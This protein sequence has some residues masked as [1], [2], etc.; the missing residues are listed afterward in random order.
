MEQRSGVSWREALE[1]GTG[2]GLVVAV[3]AATRG[4][5]VL[6]RSTDAKATES[7]RDALV[8]L[9]RDDAR[10]KGR[11]DPIGRLEYRG[12][13]AHQAGESVVATVGPWLVVSN[14]QELSRSI[15]DT[16]LDG[17]PTLAGEDAFVAAR[18][19]GDGSDAGAQKVGQETAGPATATAFLRLAPLRLMAAGSAA[20]DRTAKSDNPAAELLFGGLAGVARNSPYLVASLRMR[21]QG[22]NLTVTSPHDAE[23]VPQSRAFFFAPA[24]QAGGADMPLRPEG[25]LLSLTTYRDLAAWWQA[26]PDTYT[27]GVAAKMAQADS[28]LS[29]FLGGK[30]FGTD[31]LGAFAP[32]I[33]LVVAGQDYAAAGVPVPAIQL[34]AGAIVFRLREKEAARAGVKKHFRVAFQSLVAFANLDG[35]SKGRPLLE[36]RTERRGKAEILY[37]TYEPSTPE[38]GGGVEDAPDVASDAEAP[39]ADR[40]A[41]KDIFYNFAPALVVAGDRLMVSSTKQLAEELVDLA[42]KAGSEKVAQNTLLEVSARPIARLL[43]NNREQLVAQNMLEKGHGRGAAEKEVDVFVALVDA[44]GNARVS[45]TPTDKTISLAIEIEAEPAK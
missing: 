2:G 10:S 5:V 22:V 21:E 31:V 33:Q 37:A 45:L 38:A 19:V 9:A 25:M 17:G 35:A 3:D 23:W 12:L 6:A 1:V 30:T 27:E 14:K 32:Q 44:I 18:K 4:V 13:V 40:P 15:A 41:E 16:L 36:M 20:F 34:P 42:A 39:G 8:S 7:V 11:P 43:R 28:G 24:G 26:G 29:T